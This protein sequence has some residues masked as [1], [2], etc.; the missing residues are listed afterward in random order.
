MRLGYAT[1][2]LPR[3]LW[4]IGRQMSRNSL[5]A[6]TSPYLLQHKDNP[7][8]WY[9]WGAA[10]FERAAAEDKPILLSV[11][12]SSCHWCHVMAHE[13]F[14]DPAT[15]SVMNDL[16]VNIKVDREERPDVDSIY[17]SA[18]ALLGQSGGWPLTMF[19]TPD[20]QPFWGGTYFPPDPRY[21]RPGFPDVLRSVAKA[22]RA[23]DNAI[24][25]NIKALSE[26]L[27]KLN[28]PASA[29]P[30]PPGIFLNAAN[31][32]VRE[33]DPFEG[34]LGHAPKFPNVPVFALLWRA[35]LRT[36]L[37]PYG[38]AVRLTLERISQGGIYDHLGGGFAR[39][40]VDER[41]LV[42][43]FEKMLYDNAQLIE[44]ATLV[45]QT[46]RS[47]LLEARVRET[48]GW[49]LRDLRLADG[50]FAGSFDADSEGEEGKF[51]VWSEAEIDAALGAESA[52][53]KRVYGVTSEGNWEHSNILNR[54]DRPELLAPA[55]EAKLAA[56][57]NLLLARRAA[58]VPPGRDDKAMP[59]WNGLAIAALVEAG[60]VF[61]EPAWI[62]AARDAFRF[63]VE[64]MT[65]DGRLRH[66]FCAG[67]LRHPATL[68]DYAQMCRAGLKLYELDRDRQAFAAVHDWIRVLDAHY[69][70]SAS[71]G[72]FL[73]AEDTPGLVHRPKSAV[74]NAT[75]SGNGCM[76]EVLARAYLLGGDTSHR[77]RAEQIL[78][79]FSG[80]VARNP[81]GYCT[82]MNGAEL[83][84]GATQIVLAGT[85][86]DP[87]AAALLAA[88]REIAIPERVLVRLYPGEALP[89]R[90]P[91]SGKT[92]LQGLAAGYICRG[93]VCSL[94][95]TDAAAFRAAI[96][97]D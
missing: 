77:D 42:P 86:A 79:A 12:Y 51:Y 94:P 53:F 92:A 43:H 5:D 70:D 56:Q 89:A 22:Y 68:D 74:D 50:A 36:G 14:E 54:L 9:S 65:Q 90:H 67:E 62:A 93:P 75:P 88:V 49:M 60:F 57:R 84:E 20:R 95:L 32:L 18:L 10:A 63:V 78:T 31:R 58:R 26:A 2:G 35:Y 1:Q 23:R 8:H 48:I 21:G 4:T 25:S 69:W 34:G 41:W 66:S 71:G 13:S 47:P 15:A 45:Y 83:L 80:E 85:R 61:S 44:L 29:G 37:E 19:L 24:T 64:R 82:L 7:V 46:G 76:V 33:V 38:R 55:A 28:R 91:A 16:F 30:L 27:G 3:N 96:A 87:S 59:D 81:F 97:A 52:A 40:A 72:Y 6:E 73:S 17:Q 11:G 39:Y